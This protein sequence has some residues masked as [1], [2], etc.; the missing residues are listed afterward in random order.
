[1]IPPKASA[2]FVWRMEDVLDV[3][4]RPYDPMR[5]LVCMDET[6]KQLLAHTRPPLPMEAGKPERIDYEY[7]RGGVGN[8]F[9]FSEPLAARRW[10]HVSDHRTK[11]DW[12]E[13]V[14]ELVD[15][16]YPEAERIVLVADNLNIHSPA[17]LYEAYPPEEAKR[18]A[19][20]LEIH[21]T[22]KHGSWLNIAEIELS[23]LGRQC[24]SRRIPDLDGLVEAVATWEERR[25]RMGGKVDW[26]FTTQDARIKLRKLYPS[27]GE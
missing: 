17:S 18:L 14:K 22:P 2:E 25:N 8:V 6:S 9:L 26:R 7:S 16:R 4:T 3:Y 10:V 20:K 12:A 21:H 15:V 5:P 24:L 23:V 13:C 19:D 1:M 27:I 11:L